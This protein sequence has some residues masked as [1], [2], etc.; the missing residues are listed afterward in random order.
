MEEAAGGVPG[1]GSGPY[2]FVPFLACSAFG[3][4]QQ[5]SAVPGIH[6]TKEDRFND[7]TLPRSD[8]G[9]GSLPATF[10]RWTTAKIPIHVLL[11]AMERAYNNT[12]APP[13]SGQ[14]HIIH[15]LDSHYELHSVALPHLERAAFRWGRARAVMDFVGRPAALYIQKHPPQFPSIT[16]QLQR[17]AG[18]V[19]LANYADS[20]QCASYVPILGLSAPLHCPTAWP[21]PNYELVK[22]A[23]MR[24]YQPRRFQQQH[25]SS[26]RDLI[27]RVIWRG[28]PT[29]RPDIDR[30][31]RIA[32]CVKALEFPHLVDAKLT[33]DADKFP[34]TKEMANISLITTGERTTFANHRAVLDTDGNSWS[35]RFASLLCSA[36]VVLKVQPDDVDYFFPTLQPNVH[37]LPVHQN[38][39]NLKEQAQRAISDP[40]LAARLVAAAN[41]WCERHMTLGQLAVDTAQIWEAYAEALN[42]TTQPV[43]ADEDDETTTVPPC[44]ERLLARYPFEKHD[45]W[46]RKDWRFW[47]ATMF[48]AHFLW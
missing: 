2:Y 7:D 39:S 30:N 37:Y 33:F 8:D 22:L 47:A 21:V 42:T 9:N 3:R 23:L 43:V 27:P 44:A 13:G 35:S 34:F 10:P 32:L 1:G 14:F 38:F 29:G 40:K 15:V 6:A 18:L 19:M 48:K 17:N 25:R 36:Q 31:A 11:E 24:R 4:S 20:Q 16:A 26:W 28:S 5:R 46:N 12:P 45:V 41:A